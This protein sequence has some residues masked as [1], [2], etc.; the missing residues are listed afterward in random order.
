[1]KKKNDNV[2]ATTINFNWNIRKYF[3]NVEITFIQYEK[4]KILNIVMKKL[5]KYCKNVDHAHNIKYK[6]YFDSQTS[7]KI[8]QIISSTL[9]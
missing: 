7:L 8:I 2:I 3:D 9:N 1:M 4:L 6:I 5:M